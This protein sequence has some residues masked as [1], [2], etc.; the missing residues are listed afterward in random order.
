MEQKVLELLN[1][2]VI[3]INIGLKEFAES[4]E[5]QGIEVAQVDWK[6]PAGGD[7]E[8]EALLTRLI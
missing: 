8:M 4:L 5:E 6:P 2:P 1:R 3:A 7:K